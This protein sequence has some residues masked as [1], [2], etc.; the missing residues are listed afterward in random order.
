M[1]TD[2][3]FK[4]LRM[5]QLVQLEMLIELD[6]ICKNNKIKYQLYSGTLLGAVRHKKFI[7]WDDDV[8][9]C[10]LRKDYDKLIKILGHELKS[11]YFFQTHITDKNYIHAFARIRKN[12]TLMLQN[13]YKEIDMSQVQNSV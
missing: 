4:V 13:Y 9:V 1:E 11:K 12:N 10:L 7:P 8:D 3:N 2:I 5:I 6:K